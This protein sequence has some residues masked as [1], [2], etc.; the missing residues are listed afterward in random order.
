MGW[1]EQQDGN[2]TAVVAALQAHM[3][4]NPCLSSGDRGREPQV[5]SCGD[6]EM[7]LL[8]CLYKGGSLPPTWATR[9]GR[10]DG[11]TMFL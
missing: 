4:Q 3:A 9:R 7:H 6:A 5:C 11:E 2:S 1:R 8:P 10:R